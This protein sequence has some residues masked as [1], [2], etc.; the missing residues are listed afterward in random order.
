MSELPCL[1][2]GRET[3]PAM[4]S[5]DTETPP[6]DAML[7]ISYGNYGSRV[8]DS[9]LGNEYLLAVICDQCVTQ[10]GMKGIVLHCRRR[11]SPLADVIREK[12]VP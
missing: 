6:A 2:C 3:S 4:P 8:F 10:A 7:F 12:W 9:V 1:K 11:N 5:P